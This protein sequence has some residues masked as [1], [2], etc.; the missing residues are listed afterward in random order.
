MLSM[1]A[2]SPAL[3]KLTPPDEYLKDC[4]HAT[5]P[6]RTQGGLADYAKREQHALDDCNTD[7]AA[8][9]AWAAP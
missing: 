3:V 7:K 5:P 1:T 6:D 8:L 4:P 9:R 2:C